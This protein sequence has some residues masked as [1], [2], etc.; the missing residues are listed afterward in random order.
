MHA[1]DLYTRA[2]T[3]LARGLY[4]LKFVPALDPGSG[5]PELPIGCFLQD[6]ENLFDWFPC[7]PEW[8]LPLEAAQELKH[9]GNYIGCCGN[10]GDVDNLIDPANGETIGALIND[11]WT[12]QYC[13]I[14]GNEAQAVPRPDL[15]PGKLYVGLIQTPEH[16]LLLGIAAGPDLES[17]HDALENRCRTRLEG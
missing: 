10:C 17:I 6:D 5:C 3:P 11:C 15:P 2:G 4:G 16:P 9:D 7:K 12:S 13:R 8:R 14:K 1:Y